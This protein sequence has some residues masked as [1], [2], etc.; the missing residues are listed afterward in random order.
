MTLRQVFA[1]WYRNA[2]IFRSSMVDW[3]TV[4]FFPVTFVL[5]VGLFS[6]FV[7]DPRARIV[8]IIGAMGWS[9]MFSSQMD[10]G[11]T[12]LRDIWFRSFKK[13]RTLPVSDFTMIAANW[14]FGFFRSGMTILTAAA[15]VNLA[16]GFDFFGGNFL[17]TLALLFGA[18]LFGLAISILV[19]SVIL[20]AGQRA[21][22][23]VYSIT[24][25][26]VL[27]SGVFYPVSLLPAALQSVA[28]AVPLTYFFEGMRGMFLD[29]TVS[30]SYLFSLYVLDVI[31]IVIAWLIFMRVE[32]YARRKGLYG[33][34]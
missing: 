8:L 20:L 2:I 16:F 13:L 7:Q 1:F 19:S 5:S 18:N 12:F 14:S 32:R 17:Y 10:G 27:L 9:Y 6:A 26:L 33:S 28:L 23:M 15:V 3:F 25:V 29:G 22:V 4:F 31:Y 24:D 34:M 30:M 11:Y 21:D